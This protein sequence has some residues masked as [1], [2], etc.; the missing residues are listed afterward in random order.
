MQIFGVSR[1]K[2]EGVKKSATRKYT[3]VLNRDYR[4]QSGSQPLRALPE[5]GLRQPI[6]LGIV[7]ARNVRDG[8]VEGARQLAAGPVKRIE[9]RAAANVLTGHLAHDY[10]RVGVDM[11]LSR[12]ERHGVLQSF[13]ES[14]VFGDIVVLVAD[15]F[16][17]SNRPALAAID[18]NP[19]ARRPGISQAATV[20]VGHEF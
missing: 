8:K 17:D 9:A 5:R 7:F 1:G 15:P 11:Q 20:H 16:C 10:F 18:D 19:N 6:R 13:H 3:E 14:G 2:L 12:L 4:D